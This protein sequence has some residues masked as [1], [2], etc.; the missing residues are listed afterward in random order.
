MTFEKEKMQKE[1]EEFLDFSICTN[2]KLINFSYIFIA[3]E[4]NQ[5]VI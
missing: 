4:G 3:S 1:K 2:F 5:G